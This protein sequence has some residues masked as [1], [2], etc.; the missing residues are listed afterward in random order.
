V[1]VNVVEEEEGQEAPINHNERKTSWT[2]RNT[3]TNRSVSVSLAVEKVHIYP[4][5]Y[6]F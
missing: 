6:G 3:K 2:F 1:A 5:F 4:F